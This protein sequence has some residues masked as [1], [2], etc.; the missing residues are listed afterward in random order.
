MPQAKV[1]ESH[2][3]PALLA[4]CPSF[5]QRW[6]EYVSDEAYVPN[7]VYV[8]AGEFARHMCALLQAGTVNEFSAVFVAVE[9]LLEEGNE[10]ACNA[11]T[12]GLL[13]DLY[14]EAE[15]AGISPRE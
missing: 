10:D 6:D 1:T 7:Q 11:V 13:E 15:N 12:T 8:D 3:L 4:V 5:R 9:H 14:F 2:V